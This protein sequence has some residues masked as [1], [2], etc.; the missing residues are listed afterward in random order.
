MLPMPDVN[1][2]VLSAIEPNGTKA[3]VGIFTAEIDGMLIDGMLI[4]GF[5]V[6]VWL[7]KSVVTGSAVGASGGGAGVTI[8]AP[9]T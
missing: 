5:G 6:T 2:P 7:A 8:S 4:A 1:S 9:F 3:L